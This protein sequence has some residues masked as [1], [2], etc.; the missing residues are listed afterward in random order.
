MGLFGNLLSKFNSVNPN[1]GLSFSD[2]VGAAGSGWSPAQLE[3]LGQGRLDRTRLSG[4]RDQLGYD[5]DAAYAPQY[6]PAT[7]IDPS[8]AGSPDQ[9]PQESPKD[10]QELVR[11]AILKAQ[12]QGLDVG[13]V[14]GLIDDQNVFDII[15]GG[16]GAYG[17]VNRRTGG[18]QA[19]QLPNK[20]ADDKQAELK[21]KIDALI[22]LGEQ[23]RAAA[24]LSSKKTSVGGF[25]PKS[26]ARSR[27]ASSK[28]L[29][30]LPSGRIPVIVP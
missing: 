4:I 30:P 3:Q 26:P 28:T 13:N 8:L 9:L 29:P 15:N 12:L 10:P 16:D 25:A 17:V 11:R 24:G 2:R 1:T 18:V 6:T 14:K 22:A 5:I 27:T 23:R 20:Y 21:A 19:G 7:S